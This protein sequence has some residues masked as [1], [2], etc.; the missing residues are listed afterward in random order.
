Q[1][2]LPQLDRAVSCCG[3]GTPQQFDID[4]PS[5][6]TAAGHQGDCVPVQPP[7]VPDYD[8]TDEKERMMLQPVTSTSTKAYQRTLQISMR[9]EVEL[10]VTRKNVLTGNNDDTAT[11]CLETPPKRNS[12]MPDTAEVLK[13]NPVTVSGKL[14][15]FLS[16][17]R[18]IQHQVVSEFKEQSNLD[19]P[20]SSLVSTEVDSSETSSSLQLEEP[21]LKL[22]TKF[23]HLATK[24]KLLKTV[25]SPPLPRKSRKEGEKL[26]QQEYMEEGMQIQQN[27]HSKL[28]IV[29]EDHYFK[30]NESN[31]VLQ[32]SKN[33]IE[34]ENISIS[35]RPTHSSSTAPIID[36]LSKMSLTENEL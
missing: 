25:L 15:H 10:F 35:Q 29:S 33:D 30:D 13:Q 17:K 31:F 6:S 34:R 7:A 26:K 28:R 8:V 20:G 36:W 18:R 32:Q 1:H 27:C 9:K 14:R 16:A 19:T 23:R 3:V 21:K 2:Q 4:T 22:A 12:S 11:E 5:T 24:R